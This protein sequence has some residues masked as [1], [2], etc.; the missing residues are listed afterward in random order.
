M[1]HPLTLK[2]KKSRMLNDNTRLINLS[3]SSLSQSTMTEIPRNALVAVTIPEGAEEAVMLVGSASANRWKKGAEEAV[4][5][6]VESF[7]AVAA[8]KSSLKIR[9]KDRTDV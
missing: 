3:F 9:A 1:A 6:T 4:T 5:K 2:S 8:P 7:R